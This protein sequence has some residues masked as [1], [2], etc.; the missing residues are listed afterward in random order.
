VGEAL[1]ALDSVSAG[2]KVR[3]VHEGKYHTG[4]SAVPQVVARKP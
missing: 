4:L 1:S 2:E 3:E